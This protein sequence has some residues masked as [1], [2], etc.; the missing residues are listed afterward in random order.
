MVALLLLLLHLSNAQLVIENAALDATHTYNNHVQVSPKN[1]HNQGSEWL[2]TVSGSVGYHW[3]ISFNND[4]WKF[5]SDQPSTLTLKVYTNSTFGN[6][7]NSFDRDIL[8]SF[9]QNDNKYIF[10]FIQ[11]DGKPNIFYPQCD[12]SSSPSRS[13]AI[14]NIEALLDNYSSGADRLDKSIQFSNNYHQP[15]PHNNNSACCSNQSPMIFK[16]INNPIEGY[17]HHIYTNPTESGWKQQCGFGEAWSSNDYMK[18]FISGHDIGE[19]LSVTKFELSMEYGE[20]LTTSLPTPQPTGIY[21]RHLL[22]LF[23]PH[24]VCVFVRYIQYHVQGR[25]YGSKIWTIQW[26]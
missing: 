3:W 12:T 6:G 4:K 25:S 18:I 8:V 1:V 2:L 14:G 22:V 21:L 20:P 17:S 24:C 16:I 26:I 15:K 13:F 11:L 23:L 9:S 10:N 19:T 7:D 5:Q